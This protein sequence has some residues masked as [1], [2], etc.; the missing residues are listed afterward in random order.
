MHKNLTLRHKI[1]KYTRR[2]LEDVEYFIEID[3]PLLTRTTPEGA[4][5]FLVPSR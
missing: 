4:R 3:T 1:V 5:D 2:Y